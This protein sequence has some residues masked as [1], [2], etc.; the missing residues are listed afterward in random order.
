VAARLGDLIQQCDFNLPKSPEIVLWRDT[1]AAGH[2]K[3]CQ[4]SERQ[5]MKYAVMAKIAKCANLAMY[6]LAPTPN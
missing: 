5:C 4:Q 3:R 2:R 6:L 1:P